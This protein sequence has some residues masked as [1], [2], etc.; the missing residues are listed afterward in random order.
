M[1][2]PR[3]AV[4]AEYRVLVSK[5]VFAPEALCAVVTED[6]GKVSAITRGKMSIAD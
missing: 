5:R 2:Y 4:Y 1:N 3:A 6:E